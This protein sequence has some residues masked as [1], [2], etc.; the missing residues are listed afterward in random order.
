MMKCIVKKALVHHHVYAKVM[1]FLN[2]E[3]VNVYLLKHCLNLIYVKVR[4]KHVHTLVH[5][6]I[7]FEKHLQIS[8]VPE[9]NTLNISSYYN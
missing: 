2:V 6:H 4:D 5:K 1:P 9:N 7:S 8:C 3:I